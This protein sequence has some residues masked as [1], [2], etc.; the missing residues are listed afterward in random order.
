MS[1]NS[2]N[3]KLRPL[4]Q[5]AMKTP[6]SRSMTVLSKE[7]GEEYKKLNYT[8]RM[9]QTGRPVSPH[10]TIYTFPV[11]AISSITNRVTGVAMAL[12]AAGLGTVEI[13]GGSGTALSLMETIGSQGF[14]IAA[15]AKFAVAFP[16]VYHY[17]GALR[18]FAW[19]YKP[20]MLTNVD[21]EKSSW[22]LI[23]GATVV[24]GIAMFL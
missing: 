24:S 17:S 14:L 12:G 8:N 2:V 13:L 23:G 7:S 20:D 10:V 9:K 11:T 16:V 22:A 15:P 1:L 5:R 3:A 6:A 19:D 18:H 21:A 4:V